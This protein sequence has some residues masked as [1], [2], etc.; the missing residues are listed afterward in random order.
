MFEVRE[1]LADLKK[2][3]STVLMSSHQLNEVQE[4][5][6]D[7]ALINQ[8]KL[9]KTGPVDEL[10][11]TTISRRLE[12]KVKQKVTSELLGTISKLDG[13]SE[14]E[15]AGENIF[16]M[17]LSG[18]DDAQANLLKSLIGLDLSVISFKESGVALENLYMSLIK[19]SR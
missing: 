16:V 19:D 14:T 12:V 18:G 13:I 1:I 4:I 8:G 6:E 3:D 11:A 5:C 7:V 9:L 15:P 17:S 2:Q 10:V